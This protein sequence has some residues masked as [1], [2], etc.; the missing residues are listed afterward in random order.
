MEMRSFSKI[1]QGRNLEDLSAR[2]PVLLSCVY[3]WPI[4]MANVPGNV[5][6][7]VPRVVTS[8]QMNRTL[9]IVMDE[10]WQRWLNLSGQGIVDTPHP[11]K[12]E[13]IGKQGK[14]QFSGADF[15]R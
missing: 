11:T 9:F 6:K 15:T 14:H 12:A 3:P 7:C 13:R 2:F 4:S 1:G 5:A 10:A 8:M